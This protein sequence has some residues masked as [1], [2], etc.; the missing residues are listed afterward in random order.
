MACKG[1]NPREVTPVSSFLF[2][3]QTIFT[4]SFSYRCR[5]T[6]QLYEKH[7]NSPPLIFNEPQANYMERKVNCKTAIFNELQLYEINC[8]N[9]SIQ[10]KSSCRNVRFNDVGYF[11]GC[12]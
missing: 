6:T 1:S 10:K 2:N 7:C 8:N 12:I 4:S 9:I 3:I 5:A 11:R